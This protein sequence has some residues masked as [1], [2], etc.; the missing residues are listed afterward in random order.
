MTLLRRPAKDEPCKCEQEAA[1]IIGMVG[2]TSGMLELPME[3]A[4]IT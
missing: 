1:E 3:V 4:N 2:G